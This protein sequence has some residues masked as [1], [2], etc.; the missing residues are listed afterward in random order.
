M[1]GQSQ[2]NVVH[3]DFR[4]DDRGIMVKFLAGT[5]GVTLLHKH[6]AP[7]TLPFSVYQELS[8]MQ[9][10]WLGCEVNIHH[11]LNAEVKNVFMLHTGTTVMLLEQL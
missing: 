3:I 4:L 8:C 7:L 6:S 10:K 1:D 5:V 2:S 9:V 11:H